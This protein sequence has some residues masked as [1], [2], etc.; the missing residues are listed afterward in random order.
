M[1]TTA[2]A[3][4]GLKY[5]KEVVISTTTFKDRHAWRHALNKCHSAHHSPDVTQ[6]VVRT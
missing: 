5:V 6:E 4:L 2:S 1:L 3:E